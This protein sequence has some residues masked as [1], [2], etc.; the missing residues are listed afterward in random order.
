MS[1]KKLSWQ[2]AVG[3]VTARPTRRSNF[4]GLVQFRD[5][6]RLRDRLERRSDP[7]RSGDRRDGVAQSS[8]AAVGPELREMCHDLRQP[9]ASASA[10]ADVLQTE[11][12]LSQSGG[13]RLQSLRRELVRLSTM[14]NHALAPPRPVPVSLAAVVRDVCTASEAE[15]R[16]EIEVLIRDLPSVCGDPALLSRMVDNLVL[17]ARA[18]AGSGRVR[19]VV[20]QD[21][22]HGFLDV[23]DAGG[24][25][26]S[27]DSPGLG[28]LIVQGIVARHGGRVDTSRSD[29]GGLRVRLS[30][31]LADRVAVEGSG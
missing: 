1:E 18:A 24:A 28:L 6:D 21:R 5:P 15:P 10:L 19:V 30:F 3:E 29:L 22:D 4:E 26:G 17:N 31:P 7:A 25:G 23:E 11:P 14:I 12:G 27:T 16:T 20:S 9:L 13:A 8:R 2:Q